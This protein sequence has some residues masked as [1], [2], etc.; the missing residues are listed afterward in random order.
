MSTEVMV[1]TVGPCSTH[2]SC[3]FNSHW[4][5][6]YFWLKLFET[7]NVN[8]VQKCQKSQ[9]FVENENLECLL[10]CARQ[11]VKQC[12]KWFVTKLLHNYVPEQ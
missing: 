4:R 12:V 3:E 10:H 2:I 5:Q 9:I 6:L 8:F 11:L 1:T 7:I